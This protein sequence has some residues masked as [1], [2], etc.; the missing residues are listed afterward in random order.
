MACALLVRRLLRQWTSNRRQVPRSRCCGGFS[1]HPRPLIM[2]FMTKSRKYLKEG[3]LLQASEKGWAAAAQSVK[4]FGPWGWEHGGHRQ[5][6][7]V[8]GRLA[9][10]T[11]NENGDIRSMFH[12]ASSLHQNF[13]EDWL[14]ETEIQHCLDK[15]EN[16]I[17]I[18]SRL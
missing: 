13:Y 5:L 3:D 16:F 17:N 7:R 12:V 11:K 18:L 15:V 4:A 2:D 6:F 10:E 9:E 14:G 8:V 1:N